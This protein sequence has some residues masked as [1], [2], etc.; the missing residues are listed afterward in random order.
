MTTTT[1]SNPT[2]TTSAANTATAKTAAQKAAA[3]K[4]ARL[5][6]AQ[7]KKVTHT[8]KTIIIHDLKVFPKNVVNYLKKYL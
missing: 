5:A 6:A 4:A 1:A 2:T 7:T 3:A 8:T